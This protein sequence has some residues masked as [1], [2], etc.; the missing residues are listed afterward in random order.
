MARTARTIVRSKNNRRGGDSFFRTLQ[1]SALKIL[2]G[3]FQVCS[4]ALGRELTSCLY[5]REL[6][7]ASDLN[8]AQ[9]SS[10]SRPA[11]SRRQPSLECHHACLV[12]VLNPLNDVAIFVRAE[13]RDLRLSR[14]LVSQGRTA[15]PTLITFLGAILAAVRCALFSRAYWRPR[16]TSGKGGIEPRMRT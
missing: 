14:M 1:N 5:S 13:R 11:V 10:I 3:R 8:C 12:R 2:N 15:C 9:S 4:C 16:P 7:P 6:S